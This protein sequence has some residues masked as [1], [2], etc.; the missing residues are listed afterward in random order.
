MVLYLFKF[1]ILCKS[2]HIPASCDE[3]KF[4]QAE[5]TKEGFQGF[6]H[7]R[8]VKKPTYKGG[9]LKFKFQSAFGKIFKLQ[10]G[11]VKWNGEITFLPKIL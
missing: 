5:I 1:I 6:I 2:F 11:N 8:P 7:L 4:Y 10:F 9:R 3:I